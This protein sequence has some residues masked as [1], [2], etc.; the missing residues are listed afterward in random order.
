M[1]ANS[2]PAL[3]GPEMVVV[4]T[5]EQSAAQRWYHEPGGPA[6]LQ[7]ACGRFRREGQQLPRAGAE[8]RRF[9]A[10]PECYPDADD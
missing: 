2:Q 7:A 10:C 4:G 5:G 8:R 1:S 9:S 6:G 3:P